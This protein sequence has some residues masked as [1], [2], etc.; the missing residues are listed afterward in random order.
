M[1]TLALVRTDRYF[2]KSMEDAIKEVEARDRTLAVAGHEIRT[3]LT[4]LKLQAEM[5]LSI[6]MRA[7]K[8]GDSPDTLNS[9]VPLVQNWEKQLMRL[10]QLA[11]D[12]LSTSQIG[13][14]TFPIRPKSIDLVELI[15][16]VIRSH[17][18][19]TSQVTF[20]VEPRLSK[21]VGYWDPLRIEQVLLNLLN[22]AVNYGRE[23]PIEIHLSVNGGLA[24]LRI[25]DQGIGICP[26]DI[27]R[28]FQPYERAES[29]VCVNGAGLGLYVVRAIVQAHKGKVWVESQVD[30]G[31]TFIV[32]LP[33]TSKNK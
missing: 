3:P 1:T 20:T 30:C 21:V 7:A 4:V 23:N 25:K 26:E 15:E 6:L 5:V 22:N 24:K 31:S 28:I 29:S 12:M 19:K 9:I 8:S 14:G 13:H 2:F 10:T 18:Y 11:N 16:G 17:H 33:V 27:Q 32:E